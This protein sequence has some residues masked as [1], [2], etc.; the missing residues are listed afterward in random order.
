MKQ[1]HVREPWAELAYK[2][3]DQVLQD[4]LARI[5]ILEARVRELEVRAEDDLSADDHMAARETV[6]VG[7]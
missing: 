2:S 6:P 5:Q 7:A 1:L 3:N 4:M